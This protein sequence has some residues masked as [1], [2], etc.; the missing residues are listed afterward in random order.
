MGGINWDFH[1]KSCCTAR[2]GEIYKEV[3]W[4][5]G[6][7]GGAG[8]GAEWQNTSLARERPLVQ[9]KVLEICNKA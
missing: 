7:V 8:H 4:M 5:G 3:K 6:W 1:S 2:T 9:C